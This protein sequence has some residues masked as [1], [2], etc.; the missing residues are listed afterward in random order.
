MN[1]IVNP[2]ICEVFSREAI[3]PINGPMSVKPR[4]TMSSGDV[5]R[6]LAVIGC[7]IETNSASRFMQT[8]TL[9][10]R[11]RI[12]QRTYQGTDAPKLAGTVK[13]RV[14][15]ASKYATRFFP[16]RMPMAFCE[17]GSGSSLKKSYD[18]S[19]ISSR[20]VDP[21]LIDVQIQRIRIWSVINC[22]KSDWLI[23]TRST[24]PCPV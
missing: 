9:T 8:L 1:G 10:S 23:S 2:S 20:I 15:P 18:L 22:A 13:T 14:A 4:N 3:T 5:A 21:T 19:L 24:R 12:S 6:L 11:N 7:V 16:T 17:G